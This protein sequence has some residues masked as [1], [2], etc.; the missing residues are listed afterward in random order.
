VCWDIK[1][2]ESKGAGEEKEGQTVFNFIVTSGG[3]GGR[4]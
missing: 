3:E 1:S 4:I 2:I